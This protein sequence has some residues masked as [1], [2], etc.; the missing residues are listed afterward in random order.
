MRAVKWLPQRLKPWVK[1]RRAALLEA[2]PFK[3]SRSAGQLSL[4]AVPGI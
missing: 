3:Q 1:G 4:V 2:E